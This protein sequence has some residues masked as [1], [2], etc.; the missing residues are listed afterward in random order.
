M[1]IRGKEPHRSQITVA[2]SLPRLEAYKRYQEHQESYAVDGVGKG[3]L[4]SSTGL[5]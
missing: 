1:V 2:F 3:M 4:P 5:F